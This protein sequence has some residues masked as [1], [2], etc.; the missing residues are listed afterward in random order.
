MNNEKSE[1]LTE[2]MNKLSKIGFSLVQNVPDSIDGLGRTHLIVTRNNE[3]FSVRGKDYRYKGRASFGL[4][5]VKQ[6]DKLEHTLL[7]YIKEENQFYV[8]DAAYVLDSGSLYE[9]P[10]K[11]S[12]SRTWIEVDGKVGVNLADYLS[13]ADEPKSMAG[14]NKMLTSFQ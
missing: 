11:H 12:I 9:E 14:D 5:H 6:A 4:E 13:D 10:S 3:S 7:S 1:I 2:A 8:F